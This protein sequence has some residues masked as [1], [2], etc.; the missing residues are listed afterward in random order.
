MFSSQALQAAA[1]ASVRAGEEQPACFALAACL[2]A[3][4]ARCPPGPQGGA[5]C[6][7]SGPAAA[8][9]QAAGTRARWRQAPAHNTCSMQ[10]QN[11]QLVLGGLNMLPV[12]DSCDQQRTHA[13]HS[14]CTVSPPQRLFLHCRRTL[15]RI[16]HPRVAHT[17]AATRM[18]HGAWC[19]QKKHWWRHQSE[20]STPLPITCHNNQC[21]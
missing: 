15:P 4:A 14:G 1:L 2:P 5:A 13:I 20:G 17:N 10:Q 19:K 8:G 16:Q 9:G 3:A 7:H 21:H 12:A 6:R 18:Q 11:D